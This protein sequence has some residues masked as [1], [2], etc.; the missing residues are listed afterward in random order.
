MAV[1]ALR[2]LGPLARLTPMETGF[3]EMLQANLTALKGIRLVEREKLHAVLKEQK[4][5]LAGLADP[6]DGR[7]SW[8]SSRGRAFGPRGIS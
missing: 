8:P 1:L 3:A 2:N 6:A 7:E 5:S 4:L